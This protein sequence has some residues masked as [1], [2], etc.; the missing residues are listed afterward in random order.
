VL[1]APTTDSLSAPFGVGP[2]LSLWL[3]TKVSN[4]S[5]VSQTHHSLAMQHNGL[6]MKTMSNSEE[7]E[8]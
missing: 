4:P 7:E 3:V 1:V 5:L 6:Y 8:H 2:Q